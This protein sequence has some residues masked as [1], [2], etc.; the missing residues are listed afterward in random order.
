MDGRDI[1]TTVFPDAEVKIFMTASDEV[2]AQRRFDEMKAKGQDPKL[3]DVMK[4]FGRGTISTPIVRFPLFP[5]P[6]MLS[7]WTIRT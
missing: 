7:C 3:E 5:G 4:T 2:R 6:P 1:G